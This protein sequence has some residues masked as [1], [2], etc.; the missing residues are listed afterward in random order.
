MNKKLKIAIIAVI[1]IVAVLVIITVYRM[2]FQFKRS[3]VKDY[4]AMAANTTG[5]PNEAYRLIIE[6]AENILKSS[7]LSKAVLISAKID[8][9][10]PELALVQ[11]ALAQCYSLGFIEVPQPAAE[12]AA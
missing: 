12:Q 2:F 3:K 8:N 7:D 9:V 6:C 4:A 5:A 11:A 10:D 1:A